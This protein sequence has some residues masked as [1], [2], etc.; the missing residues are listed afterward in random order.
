MFNQC[1]HMRFRS[2]GIK[3]AK[4]SSS[5]HRFYQTVGSVLFQTMFLLSVLPDGKI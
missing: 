3:A 4:V 2:F 1:G 5:M